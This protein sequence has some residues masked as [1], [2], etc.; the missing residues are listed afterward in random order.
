MKPDPKFLIKW[1][2]NNGRSYATADEALAFAAHRMEAGYTHPVYI[3]QVIF[4]VE[5]TISTAVRSL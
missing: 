3:C 4:V 2:T 1:D 5:P